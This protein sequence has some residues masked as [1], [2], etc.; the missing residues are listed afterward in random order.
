MKT[1][2]KFT[3]YIDGKAIRKSFVGTSMNAIYNQF[4]LR[5]KT[6]DPNI[7]SAVHDAGAPCAV[8]VDIWNFCTLV[9][10][11][12]GHDELVAAQHVVAQAVT[13]LKLEFDVHVALDNTHGV[14][15]P[16]LHNDSVRLRNDTPTSTTSTS[17]R[18]SLCSNEKRSPRDRHAKLRSFISSLQNLTKYT[19]Q[20]VLTQRVD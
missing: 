18:R 15:R 9:N 13:E 14:C 10:R 6:P 2:L 16:R 20:N 3:V 5:D 19:R 8:V 7:V 17:I 4:N 11:L 1:Q 12:D